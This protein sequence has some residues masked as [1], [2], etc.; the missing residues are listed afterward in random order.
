[1]AMETRAII[2]DLGGTLV[3][4]QAPLL[5]AMR[6]AIR[7]LGLPAPAEA[8]MRA[9]LGWHEPLL[10]RGLVPRDQEA[11]AAEIMTARMRRELRQAR[12]IAGAEAVLLRLRSLGFRLAL[13]SG[14]ARETIEGIIQPLGWRLLFEVIVSADDV[15]RPRP[16]PD[17]LLAAVGRLCLPRAACLAVG[18]ALYDLRSAAACGMPFAGVLTGAQ[19]ADLADVLPRGRAL[20]SVAE[21]PKKSEIL[22]PRGQG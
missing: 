19:A 20:R 13:A 9:N 22:R 18:D 4:T 10:M 15:A 14:F 2:F 21:L 3:D 7:E 12:P 1:M 11:R 6:A 5:V 16:A 8:A 17:L